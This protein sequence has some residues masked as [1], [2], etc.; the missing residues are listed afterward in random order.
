[1]KYRRFLYIIVFMLVLS[2]VFMGCGSATQKPEESTGAGQ[3]NTSTQTGSTGTETSTTPS[4]SGSGASIN[5]PRYTSTP[6]A[7]FQKGKKV[8]IEG[9]GGESFST[10]GTLMSAISQGGYIY[11]FVLKE[12]KLHLIK[13]N[14]EVVFDK[15]IDTEK[16]PFNM[17]RRAVYYEGY[18]ATYYL[19]K[20]RNS[21]Q[22]VLVVDEDGNKVL[23]WAPEPGPLF[24]SSLS[25][26]DVEGHKAVF[27]AVKDGTFVSV[28]LDG[29][30][31][32][33]A[34]PKHAQDALAAI[35][36][37]DTIHGIYAENVFKQHLVVIDTLSGHIKGDFTLDR[38]GTRV[39]ARWIDRKGILLAD[40][41]QKNF[42]V[43]LYGESG[44]EAQYELKGP[45]KMIAVVGSKDDDMPV[46]LYYQHTQ[47]YTVVALDGS[48]KVKWQYEGDIKRYAKLLNIDSIDNT[49]VGYIGADG[50][51]HVVL[52]SP[53]GKKI[54]DYKSDKLYALYPSYSRRDDIHPVAYA[55]PD[56]NGVLLLDNAGKVVWDIP[57]SS[58]VHIKAL[59][60][61]GD[62][63][64]VEAGD[65]TFYVMP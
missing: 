8:V 65:S 31:L 19:T 7:V 12:G 58:D 48:L 49:I 10:N 45:V 2:I 64:V 32:W 46:V 30:V 24:I 36:A 40:D 1:M 29:K 23:D 42:Y 18:I 13:W 56:G 25:L 6:F 33:Y 50:Y 41:R 22:R 5:L 3:G 27:I 11:L 38:E 16:E 15:V 37:E 14:G 9:R 62:G 52:L 39:Y 57:V 51:M 54:F 60:P 59:Y 20:G 44:K 55:G 35:Y 47:G 53:D 17:W 26:G 28:L 43:E 34:K 63:Y 21:F 4:G 61:S